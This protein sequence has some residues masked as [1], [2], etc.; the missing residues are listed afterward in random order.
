VTDAVEVELQDDGSM[1]AIAE[2]DW[3]ATLLDAASVW[4]LGEVADEDAVW[5]V[6]EVVHRDR[7]VRTYA[8]KV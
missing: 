8:L 5:D 7:Q 4:L 6:Y 1:V 2:R 3:Q